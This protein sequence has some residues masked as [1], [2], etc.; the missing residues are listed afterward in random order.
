M[1]LY[2]S[3]PNPVV[4]S[5]CQDEHF[6]HLDS[7]TLEREGHKSRSSRSSSATYGVLD[8]VSKMQTNPK[9]RNQTKRNKPGGKVQ[10]FPQK[11]SVLGMPVGT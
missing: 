5:F 1:P 4:Q 11:V 2:T 3:S 7:Q 10:M 8:P 6:I 9:Q